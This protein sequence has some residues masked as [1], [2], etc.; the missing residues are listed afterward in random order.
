MDEKHRLICLLLMGKGEWTPCLA[1]SILILIDPFI[2]REG[3]RVSEH[4]HQ[5]ASCS[6]FSRSILERTPVLEN[7][8]AI[9]LFTV[10]TEMFRL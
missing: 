2:P 5:D 8:F 6:R 7:M 10:F 3:N 4:D 1:W 9:W